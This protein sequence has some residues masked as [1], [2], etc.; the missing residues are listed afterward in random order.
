[1]SNGHL[2]RPHEFPMA[3]KYKD[4]IGQTF[5]ALPKS[6]VPNLVAEFVEMLELAPT[7]QYCTCEWIIHPEDVANEI[8]EGKRR[9]RR[10]AAA[11]D[12]WVHTKQGFIMGFFTWVFTVRDVAKPTVKT[13][14]QWNDED[15]EYRIVDW[16]GFENVKRDDTMTKEEFIK[17]RGS[18]TVQPVFRDTA[19]SD[20]SIPRMSDVPNPY[21]EADIADFIRR[22]RQAYEGS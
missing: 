2:N 4:G 5:L 19:K 1:M 16:D 22:W 18:S 17:R 8:P 14:D 3:T 12:C 10:G 6:D 15:T 9:K 21:S 11:W 13:P 7:E 20:V